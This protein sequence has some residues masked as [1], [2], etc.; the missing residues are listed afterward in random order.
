[1]YFLMYSSLVCCISLVLYCFLSPSS[2]SVCVLETHKIV[3]SKQK[4]GPP[5]MK[6]GTLNT[7]LGVVMADWAV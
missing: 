4:L 7:C 5:E 2:L 6:T 3:F 1:M